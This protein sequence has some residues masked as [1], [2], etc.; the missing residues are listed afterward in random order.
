MDDFTDA[1]GA[2]FSLVR[3]DRLTGGVGVLAEAADPL[4]VGGGRLALRGSADVE[5]I[6]SGER[7]TVEV[8]GERLH[9]RAEK[10]RLLL[11]MGARWRAGCFS[12]DADLSAS[13]LGSGEKT[14]GGR[15]SLGVRF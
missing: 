11:G 7:T 4:D 13:G 8:S 5:E 10:T 6:L 14:Y 1:T 12:L 3:G 2:R 9:A 15:L